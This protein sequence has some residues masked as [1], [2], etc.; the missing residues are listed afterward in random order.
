MV[1][2][3]NIVNYENEI[4]KIFIKESILYINKGNEFD[5]LAKDVLNY[6]IEY[7]EDLLWI[8]F[9]DKNYSIFLATIKLSFKDRIKINKYKALEGKKYAEFIDSLTIIIKDRDNINLVFRGWDKNRVSSK[10]LSSNITLGENVS[11][12]A[13]NCSGNYNR[14]Y[15]SCSFLDR[16]LILICKEYNKGRYF[17]YDLLDKKRI[18]DVYLPNTCNISFSIFKDKPIIFCNKMAD[19][20]LFLKYV[21]LE[22]N[23]DDEITIEERSVDLPQNIIKPL[24]SVYMGVTYVTWNNNDVINIAT[25]K[26]LNIWTINTLNN[27]KNLNYIEANIMKII[28]NRVEKFKTFITSDILKNSKVNKERESKIENNKLVNKKIFQIVIQQKNID[29]KLSDLYKSIAQEER[30]YNKKSMEYL[31]RINELQKI[32]DEK[33]KIISN[34][35]KIK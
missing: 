5:E 33:D 34:L 21:D 29:N 2:R 3:L 25:S 23:E 32:I 35:L 26:D 22:I 15:V 8:S 24:I 16:G 10:I 9:Y 11:I 12:I 14:P 19:K 27:E 7:Y 13:D 30:Y 6:H 1:K 18:A 31:V 4:Y 20:N 28:G 17:I